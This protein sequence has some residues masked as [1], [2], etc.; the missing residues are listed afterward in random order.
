MEKKEEEVNLYV[1]ADGTRDSAQLGM[2][3]PDRKQST[4][5]GFRPAEE[6]PKKE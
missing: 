1:D 2:K 3:V 4:R 6:E 5:I